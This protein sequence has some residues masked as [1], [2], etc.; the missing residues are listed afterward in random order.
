MKDSPARRLSIGSAYTAK[1][2]EVVGEALR[3]RLLIV[4]DEAAVRSVLRRYLARRGWEVMEAANAEQALVLIDDAAMK[5]D[6]VIVDL[7]MP[8]GLEGAALCQRIA[9]ARPELLSRMIVAT[10][11]APSARTALAREQLACPVLPKPFE[12]AE[13]ERALSDVLTS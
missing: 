6:A 8:G 12:L 3:R 4:D 13:L 10:G 11:D 7:H 2:L 9:A 1:P 5:F